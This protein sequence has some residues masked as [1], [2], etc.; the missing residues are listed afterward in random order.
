MKA[1]AILAQVACWASFAALVGW[2]SQAPAY[3]PLKPGH[4]LVKLSLSHAGERESACRA[5][6]AEELAKLAPN[7][8]APLDC[9]RARV[10]LRVVLEMDGEPLFEAVAPPTGINRD[11][12]SA[13]Y[14]RIEVPAG[15]HAFRARLADAP[16][17]AFRHEAR[18]QR[19]LAAGDVLVI[20]FAAAAGGFRFH[21]ER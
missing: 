3:T 12:P 21:P 11:L 2:L 5:R 18:E 9:P 20:D 16:G 19:A 14:R 17:G 13:V 7:M 15:P 6:S 1:R 4:A 10:P 8:R